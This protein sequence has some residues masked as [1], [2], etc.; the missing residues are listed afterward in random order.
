MN[1]S[2][3]H[4]LPSFFITDPMPCPYIEGMMER[5]LFTH[6]AGESADEINNNLTHAGFRRSQTIAY[7]PACDKCAACR[8]VRV[9]VEGF[10]PSRNMRKILN[11][12][13]GLTA[14]VIGPN[15][16]REQYDLLRRYLDNRHEDGGMTQMTVLDYMAMVEET[17][18][19]T[20][21]VE[22][23]NGDGH[24][25][26]CLLVDEMQDGLSLVYS[27]FEPDMVSHSLG[28]Y[29]ILDQIARAQTM[30]L[31]HVYLGYLIEDCSKMSYKKRFK[32]LQI[33]DVEGWQTYSDKK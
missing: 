28:S 8:S 13:S 26:A 29:V 17:S 25:I 20:N 14:E 22:Y 16:S 10:T 2:S 3:G 18:V 19:K 11:R 21:L 32:P 15:T 23:R 27:F 12:N 9:Q 1:Q 24:L 31:P 30:G 5:K 6:I 33:L 4:R 7:R